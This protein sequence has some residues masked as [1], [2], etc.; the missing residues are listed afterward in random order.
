MNFS[1][2]WTLNGQ[3]GRKNSPLWEEVEECLSKLKHKAGTLTLDA[4]ESGNIGPDTL[5]VRA[6]SGNYMLTLGKETDNDYKVR[7]YWD[8]SLT[9]EKLLILGDYWSERQLIKDF[10]LVVRVFKEFFDTGNVS[11][12]ILN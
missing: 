10:A 5:Q 9:S 2:K 1:L 7:F 6:E 3:G 8:P 11:A 12:D 4:F